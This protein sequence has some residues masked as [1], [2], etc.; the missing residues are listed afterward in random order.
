M[1]RTIMNVVMQDG[2]AA[3]RSKCVSPSR[4]PIHLQRWA[5]KGLLQG[6]NADSKVYTNQGG[7]NAR[8][9][10]RGIFGDDDG[11]MKVAGVEEKEING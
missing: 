11:I 7:Q 2:H 6:R 9:E 3:R 10:D 8:I 4:H 5:S 1:Q